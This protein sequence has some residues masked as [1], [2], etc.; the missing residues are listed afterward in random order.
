MRLVSR[1]TGSATIINFN[2]INSKRIRKINDGIAGKGPVIYWMSR[3]QRVNDN[4]ALLFAR[5]MAGDKGKVLVVAFALSPDFSGATFRHYDF[6]LKGLRQ[7]EKKLAALNIPFYMLAGDSP[8]EI[9]NFAKELDTECLVTEFDPLKIKRQWKRNVVDL[10]K[11]PVYEVDAHNIVPCWV[12]SQKQEYGAYTIRPKINRLLPEFFDVFPDLMPQKHHP[13]FFSANNWD[14]LYSELTTDREVMPVR[15]LIPGEEAAKKMLESFMIA[16]LHRYVR[17]GNDPNEYAQSDLS[18]YLHFGQISS[19]RVAMEILERVSSSENKT[20][21]LEQLIIRRELAENFCYYNPYYDSYKG[22]P[23]WARRTLSE[24][25]DDS[26]KYVYTADEL[27]KA[28]THDELWNA[29]QKEM[30]ITGKMHSYLRMYWAKKILEWDDDPSRAFQMALYLN[31]KYELDGTDPNGYAGCAWSIGGVHD[32]AWSERQVFGKI[33]YMNR[34]GCN[35]KFDVDMYIRRFN[36]K[37]TV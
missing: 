15:W 24:H 10:L 28:A 26:R 3:D 7:V 32:H 9:V 14:Q 12:A 37:L 29:A 21:F 1:Q 27:E 22:F 20:A 23:D 36:Q 2:M 25:A 13:E 11:K 5:Q 35:R 16:G 8:S 33:R 17:F 31:D 30:I 18:P 34:S 19:Q 6:M 4:W